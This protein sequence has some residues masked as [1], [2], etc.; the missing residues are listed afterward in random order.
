MPPPVPGCATCVAFYRRMEANGWILSTVRL[1]ARE[2]SIP[3]ANDCCGMVDERRKLLAPG[4]LLPMGIRRLGGCCAPRRIR[5][6]RQLT[7]CRVLRLRRDTRQ[8][9]NS[10][11]DRISPY[12]WNQHLGISF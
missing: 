1:M 9:E 5:S 11:Y 3:R 10:R 6:V 4:L 12:G 8:P 2:A 7:A